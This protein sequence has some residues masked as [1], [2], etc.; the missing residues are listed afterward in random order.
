MFKSWC[1]WRGTTFWTLQEMSDLIVSSHLRA[2]EA[3]ESTDRGGVGPEMGHRVHVGYLWS[4][5]DLWEWLQPGHH[6][7]S[8]KAASAGAF[9][10][11]GNLAPYHDFLLKEVP[12]SENV[13]PAT[14]NNTTTTHA[15]HVCH[16][17]FCP[18]ICFRTFKLPS[19]CVFKV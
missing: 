8:S 16:M 11:F 2:Q 9:V 12:H 13:E 18:T 14:H 4:I 10:H 17:C 15:N 7:N 3:W 5:R 19:W 6:K 1:L